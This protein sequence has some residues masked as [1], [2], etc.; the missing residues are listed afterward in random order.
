[1]TPTVQLPF[2]EGRRFLNGG[3]WTN[4]VLGNWTIS[5]VIQ[6]QSGSTGDVPDRGRVTAKALHYPV[7]RRVARM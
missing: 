6:M 5:A 7:E 3:G 4:A 1:M 2:G